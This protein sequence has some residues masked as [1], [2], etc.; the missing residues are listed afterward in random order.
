MK[1][2]IKPQLTQ[3]HPELRA[4]SPAEGAVG[5]GP[6]PAK[7]RSGNPHPHIGLKHVLGLGSIKVKMDQTIKLKQHESRK[8]IRGVCS[9][10]VSVSAY[11]SEPERVFTYR[12]VYL[13][14]RS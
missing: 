4:S 7:P 10:S 14:M 6:L 8:S 12:H 13:S 11:A 1:P 3:S 5:R 2:P 9:R